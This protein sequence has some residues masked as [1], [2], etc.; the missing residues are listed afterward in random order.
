M[1]NNLNKLASRQVFISRF[2]NNLFYGLAL[3][4]VSLTVGVVGYHEFRNMSWIDSF[5]NAS[6][7]LGGMGPIDLFEGASESAKLFGG[8]YAIFSGVLFISGT[9]IVI[10]P[11]IHRLM[12]RFH[13]E[14]VKD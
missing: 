9:A 2:L 8:L 3:I 14:D 5:L 12:H 1:K 11:L 6:M 7:I 4:F 10:S 13:L